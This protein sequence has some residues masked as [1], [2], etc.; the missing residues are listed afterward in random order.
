MATIICCRKD[1]FEEVRK[2]PLTREQLRSGMQDEAQS[3]DVLD[4]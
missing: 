2:R 1:W 3:H 4:A